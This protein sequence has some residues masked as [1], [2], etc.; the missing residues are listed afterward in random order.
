MPH[1]HLRGQSACYGGESHNPLVTHALPLEAHLQSLC[2]GWCPYA[3]FQRAYIY[4]WLRHHF[5]EQGLDI[6]VVKCVC[7]SCIPL[8]KNVLYVQ[9]CASESWVHCQGIGWYG[10]D[11]EE[12]EKYR[13]KKSHRWIRI[14]QGWFLEGS[15]SHQWPLPPPVRVSKL[16][17]GGGGR[18]PYFFK[19]DNSTV[20][21]CLLGTQ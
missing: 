14:R 11:S 10:P 7:S 19:N 17:G 5:C 2:A 16:T 20:C 18:R 3:P 13:Y 15:T 4:R 21:L 6:V 9:Y 8:V 1:T 12:K